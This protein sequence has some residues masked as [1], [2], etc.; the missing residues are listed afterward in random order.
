MIDAVLGIV[1]ASHWS[2]LVAC[3]PQDLCTHASAQSFISDRES[4]EAQPLKVSLPRGCFC[5][6]SCGLCSLQ[7]V[8]YRATSRSLPRFGVLVAPFLQQALS[9]SHV[10][11]HACLC[12]SKAGHCTGTALWIHSPCQPIHVL[13]MRRQPADAA[14]A[15]AAPH[16]MPPHAPGA[17]IQQPDAAS[18]HGA[19]GIPGPCMPLASGICNKLLDA[20]RAHAAAVPRRVCQGVQ[21]G[22]A[23]ATWRQ[24]P[25]G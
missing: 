1:G 2:V 5:V 24:S 8:L 14:S 19:P 15:L 20:A 9:R 16:C 10:R 12:T 11:P 7:I 22:S 23:A 17:C 4:Q 3:D 18:A 6:L 21:R 13:G 25:S